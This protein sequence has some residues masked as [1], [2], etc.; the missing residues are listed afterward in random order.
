MRDTDQDLTTVVLVRADSDIRDLEDI[1]GRTVATGAQDSP[2]ATLLPLAHLAASGL[3]PGAAFSVQR[4]DVMVG[5]HGDHVGGEREAVA[6]LIEGSVDA[7][8]VIDGN[9]LAF[10]REGAIAPDAVRV[11]TR[12]APYDHCT[13]TVVDDDDTDTVTRFVDLLLSMSYDDPAVRPLLDLE[14]LKQWRQGRTSGYHQLEAAVDRLGFY[15]D[16]GSVLA[17]GNYRR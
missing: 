11:L 2:Q 6:A 14:G 4:F 8:C 13:M 9:Q 7:A 17:D 10:A 15:G 16:D 12:T 3:D 5:K 1:A